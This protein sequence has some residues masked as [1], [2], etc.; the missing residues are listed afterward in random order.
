MR[1]DLQR[2]RHFAKETQAI[3]LIMKLT[4]VLANVL[5]PDH[6]DRYQQKKD[7]RHFESDT[8]STFQKNPAS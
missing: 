6:L 2:S 5:A 7:G 3:P 8:L 1:M 4:N